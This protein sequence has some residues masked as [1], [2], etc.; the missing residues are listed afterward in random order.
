[1][2]GSLYDLCVYLFRSVI[3]LFTFILF[4][5]I[6]RPPRSTRTDTLFPYTTLF[7]STGTFDIQAGGK[8]RLRK[9]T[10][11][12]TQDK[13]DGVDGELTLA[14]VLG[15]QSYSLADIEP[16]VGKEGERDLLAGGFDPFILNPLDT[17]SQSPAADYGDKEDIYAGY[18]L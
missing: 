1:M 18:L 4:L 14:D 11:E 7:R 8:A 15:R 9:K 16:V 13:Y 10:F 6:R 12:Y 17:L 2:L 5:M 3:H